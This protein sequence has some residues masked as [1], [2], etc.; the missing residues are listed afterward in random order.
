M[1]IS[2]TSYKRSLKETKSYKDL[3]VW[4]KSF[5]LS[6]LIYK[7]TKRFPKEELYALVFQMR[8]AAISIA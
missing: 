2:I 8:R 4:K 6:I 1:K 5:N 3:E 7:L